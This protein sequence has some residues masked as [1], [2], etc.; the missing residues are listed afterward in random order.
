V[1]SIKVWSFVR[2]FS[3]FARNW[4]DE[5]ASR[6]FANFEKQVCPRELF[7][8]HSNLHSSRTDSPQ[9]GGFS[10]IELR[11]LSKKVSLLIALVSSGLFASTLLPFAM[12][13]TFLTFYQ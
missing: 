4:V 10:R 12:L 11:R 3:R 7:G 5:V 9:K 2:N 13:K 6:N 1:C 8:F